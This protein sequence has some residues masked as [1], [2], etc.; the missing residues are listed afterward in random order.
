MSET[1]PLAIFATEYTP[2]LGG[3]RDKDEPVVVTVIPPTRVQWQALIK[4][5][6]FEALADAIRPLV[7]SVE[8][9]DLDLALNVP[10]LAKE[11]GDFISTDMSGIS[12]EQGND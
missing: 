7:I 9:L 8:G 11:I 12:V 3:N 5:R 6:G 4:S 2:K 1:N 10:A